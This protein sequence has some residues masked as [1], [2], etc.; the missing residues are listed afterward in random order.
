MKKSLMMSYFDGFTNLSKGESYQKLLGYFFPELVTTFVLYSVLHLVDAKFVA[1]LHSTSTYATLGV[2]KTLIHFVVKAAEGLAVG[3][4]VLCGQFNGAKEYKNAGKIITDSFWVSVIIGAIISASLYFG[5]YWIYYFYGVPEKMIH[6]GIPFLRT[7]AIGIFFSFL[8]FSFLAFLRGVKNT[9]IPMYIF[10]VGA[11]TFIFFDYALIFG[12]F[13]FPEFGLQGSAIAS[14]I[15]YTVM[16]LM[17]LLI[18][19]FKDEYKKYAI[20]L[21]SKIS[22][23]NFV[24]IIV[25]SWPVI[26]DKTIMAITYIWM[27]MM[28]SHMGKYVIASYAV[29]ADM[30]RLS[31]LPAMAFAQIITF[32]ASNDYGAGKIEDIRVNIKK[33]IFLTS[34]F[35]FIIL[36]IF[37]LFSNQ[38][39]GLFDT[40]GTFTAFSAYVFPWVSALIFFDLVQIILSGA[41][42]GLG[43]VQL[44]MWTRLVFCFFVFCPI[45]YILTKMPIESH[46]LKF[47]LIYGMFYI[48]NG[49]MS[50]VYIHVLRNSDWQKFQK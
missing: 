24:K 15:Q 2:T 44:V 19:T 3:A 42:R 41:L 30:E 22:F 50:M 26:L 43:K 9:R 14:I 34:I 27:G 17:G 1:G 28:L 7:R 49:F 33:S 38:F 23:S 25:I 36:G 16:F 37:C 8:Y 47:I 39:I 12:K 35:V 29:I 4:T 5:A 10:L 11:V 48:C 13:G 6:M 46:A 32:L 31:F 40:K 45:A 18:V 21:L 20:D